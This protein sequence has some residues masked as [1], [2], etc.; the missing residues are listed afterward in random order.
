[1]GMTTKLFFLIFF[2][3]PQIINSQINEQSVMQQT[4]NLK[5]LT[6]Q[7]KK[8]KIIDIETPITYYLKMSDS[9]KINLSFLGKPIVP[10]IIDTSEDIQII[11]FEFTKLK[12]KKKKAFTSVDFT[13]NWNICEGEGP[14]PSYSTGL[15]LTLKT[16]FKKI[17]N[18]WIMT[19]FKLKDI[20]FKPLEKMKG[21]KCIEK[22]YLPLKKE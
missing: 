15:Y 11:N 10:L 4:I 7:V 12:L 8:Q 13:P 6:D 3:T 18:Q 5:E 1:M 17:E 14:S 9:I 22:Y 16:K 2:F 21:F 19:S 20:N